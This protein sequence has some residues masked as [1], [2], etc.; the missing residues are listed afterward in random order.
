MNKHNFLAIERA[1]AAGR[2]E[3]TK[4]LFRLFRDRVLSWRRSRTRSPR[5]RKAR[6]KER[7]D[8][9]SGLLL[10][11]AV[12]QLAVLSH[13]RRRLAAYTQLYSCFVATLLML[14]RWLRRQHPVNKQPRSLPC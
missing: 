5:E 8:T 14:Y 2:N 3:K 12:G 4:F 7:A 10:W 6:R 1:A 11:R 9:K 13:L